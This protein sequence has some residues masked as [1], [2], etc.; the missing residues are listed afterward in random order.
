[1]L[2][3]INTIV[4][5]VAFIL[6]TGLYLIVAFSKPNT[7]PRRAFRLYLL[8]MVIWSLSALL[9]LVDIPRT[10]LWFRFM[11]ASGLATF[12]TIFNF[13]QHILNKRKKWSHVVL[14]YGFLACI[15]TMSTSLV[16]VSA[17]VAG[18]VVESWAEGPLLG[19]L[20][21][22]GYLVGLYSMYE[23]I[24]GYRETIDLVRRNRLWYLIFGI[25]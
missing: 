6:Y 4:P 11:S 22:P 24:R 20:V 23:L 7:S 18:G 25:G 5:I 1:M 9:V 10:T 12:V 17:T 14:L 2:L 19:V 21:G 8:A 13:V 3:I 15:L 16:I